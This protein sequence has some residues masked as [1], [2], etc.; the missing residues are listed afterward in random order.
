[1][2]ETFEWTGGAG[3]AGKSARVV[4]AIEPSMNLLHI[5]PGIEQTMHTHPSDRIGVVVSGAGQCVTPEG[6]V[7]L[8]PGRKG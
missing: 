8:V 2:L 7:D 3:F 4:A 6:L 5:P 1:M